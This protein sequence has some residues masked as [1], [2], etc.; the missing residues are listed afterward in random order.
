MRLSVDSYKILRIYCVVE[1]ID[2][3]HSKLPIQ[4]ERHCPA[5]CV[6]SDSKSNHWSPRN[7]KARVKK[8]LQNLVGA[9]WTV[10]HAK[11][12]LTAHV[13]L[14]SILDTLDVRGGHGKVTLQISQQSFPGG[15]LSKLCRSERGG[16]SEKTLICSLN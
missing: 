15:C 14:S 10:K 5:C 16:S 11:I 9:P 12:R 6:R 1:V 13:R 4:S 3:E 8:S 7:T 2:Q